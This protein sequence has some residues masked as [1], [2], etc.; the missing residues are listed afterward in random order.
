VAHGTR[1]NYF[2]LLLPN[3][4]HVPWWHCGMVVQMV[5]KNSHDKDNPYRAFYQTSQW[6]G[7]CPLY[8]QA[9]QKPKETM[10]EI[11]SEASTAQRISDICYRKIDSYLSDEFKALIKRF[12]NVVHVG[13]AYGY[14]P[15][16]RACYV[17]H[18]QSHSNF[19]R[20]LA[21]IIAHGHW[22]RLTAI[23]QCLQIEIVIGG[24]SISSRC[25]AWRHPMARLQWP[26]HCILLVTPNV[27]MKLFII[28]FIVGLMQ[29]DTSQTLDTCPYRPCLFEGMILAYNSIIAGSLARL[30]PWERSPGGSLPLHHACQHGCTDDVIQFLVGSWPQSVEIMTDSSCY[31][32]LPLH[33]ACTGK[34]SLTV[35]Q[36]LVQA[37][38]NAVHLQDDKGYLPLH[39][40]LK[41]GCMDD[42]IQ[43]LVLSWPES[44]C[45]LTNKG[46]LPLHCACEKQLLAII[47]FILDCY[48]QAICHKDKHS[49]LPLH[50]TCL[51]VA[52]L[53]LE[54]I[55]H[56]IRAWPES[57]Q[58]P[59]PYSCNLDYMNMM[60]V[61]DNYGEDHDSD[62][63]HHDY[64]LIGNA[65]PVD[66][67]CVWKRKPLRKFI[68]LLTNNMPPLHFLCTYAAKFWGPWNMV[69]MKYLLSMFP[70]DPKLFY[71]GMLPFHCACCAGS[72]WSLLKWWWDKSPTSIEV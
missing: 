29:C 34:S 36:A 39:Y 70:D 13:D 56:L 66:L 28:C 2:C 43:F 1:M 38:P 20:I 46:E 67:A 57:I 50:T 54:V 16:H 62:M 44:C 14:L 25:L 27:Q 42:V 18:H 17:W 5:H 48:P 21:T 8:E 32:C 35:I 61:N 19:N 59:C 9:L 37:W 68:C 11:N 71:H 45:I 69:T 47:C 3:A 60:S 26:Y 40:S 24:H 7:N 12:P 10:N 22:M 55:E 49:W 4:Y 65:L 23:A 30:F 41:H 52:N 31:G 51:A 64:A 6:A 58:I 15:L 53:N 33:H 72:K 63:E